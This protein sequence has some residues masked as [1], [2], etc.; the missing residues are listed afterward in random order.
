[1]ISGDS[2]YASGGVQPIVRSVTR[3][4]VS[5]DSKWMAFVAEPVAK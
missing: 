2:P 1:M 4:A 3:M 5:A